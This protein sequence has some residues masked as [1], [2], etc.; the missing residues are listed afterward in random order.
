MERANGRR[1]GREAV[2]GR[3]AAQGASAPLPAA[4]VR[5]AYAT[6]REDRAPTSKA[7]RRQG[8]PFLHRVASVSERSVRAV[9]SAATHRGAKSADG[10]TGQA[11]LSRRRER[12]GRGGGG[13]VEAG[14]DGWLSALDGTGP[15]YRVG[16]SMCGAPISDSRNPCTR[17]M[18]KYT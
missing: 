3:R 14:Q 8:R 5:S 2:A 16:Y 15:R 17:V 4:A 12:G 9:G 11:T 6:T 13:G 10:V 7:K 1:M 18:S